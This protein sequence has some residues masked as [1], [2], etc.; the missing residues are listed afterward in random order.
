MIVILA[1]YVE[2]FDSCGLCGLMKPVLR[3]TS[4]HLA[5]SS[6]PSVPLL[7]TNSKKEFDIMTAM[8]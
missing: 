8:K 3:P 5:F 2:T 6:R 1:D 4:A 7:I